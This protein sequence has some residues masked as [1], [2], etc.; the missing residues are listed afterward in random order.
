MPVT[1]AERDHLHSLLRRCSAMGSAPVALLGAGTVCEALRPALAAP[2]GLIAGVIDDDPA[3]H[4]AEWAWLR[5][6]SPGQAVEMG[7]KAVIIT[8]E[9]GAQDALFASRHRFL[10][11]GIQVFTCPNRFESHEWDDSLIEHY[12]WSLARSRGIARAY[13]RAWPTAEFKPHEPFVR[14]LREALPQGGTSCEIGPGSGLMSELLIER[15][16]LAWFV[17]ASGRGMHESLEHRLHRN[18]DKVRCVID[19][20][21]SLAGVPDGSVDL[22][23]SI[24]VFDHIKIDV[25]H[26]FFGTI[27]RVLKPRGAALIQFRAWEDR[28]IEALGACGNAPGTANI[29]Q[30]THPDHV[31]L[32]AASQGLR[33]EIAPERH[34]DAY[35][36]RLSRAG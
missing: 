4:G 1:E 26:R 36:A 7:V 30:Y 17:D 25:T 12:E 6:L 18:I 19:G 24:G 2:P 8:A 20:T 32:S 3:R 27:S 5:V 33:C 22:V 34:G 21:A 9:G 13:S 28:S 29:M 15:A 35:V 31:K 10:R 11:A 23:H 14:L 16:G